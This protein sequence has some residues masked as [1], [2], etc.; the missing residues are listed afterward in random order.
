V[1]ISVDE[2][3]CDANG[4]CVRLAPELFDLA[5]RDTVEVLEPEPAQEFWPTA[6][7]AAQ[8]CPKL[9]IEVTEGP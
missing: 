8:G 2:P 6:R 1:R 3:N 5:D 4:V 9:A 7:L